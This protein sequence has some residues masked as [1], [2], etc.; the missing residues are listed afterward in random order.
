MATVVTGSNVPMPVL[1]AASRI[2]K[3]TSGRPYGTAATMASATAD[4]VRPMIGGRL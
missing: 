2:S 3:A 4:T 1:A